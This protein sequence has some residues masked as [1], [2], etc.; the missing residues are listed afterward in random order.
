MKRVLGSGTGPSWDWSV[1]V[2]AL[3][4]LAAVAVCGSC[5]SANDPVAGWLVANIQQA[6]DTGPS[7][8]VYEG[9]GNFRVGSDAGAGLAVAFTLDSKGTGA[10]AGQTLVLYWPGHGRPG[11]GRYPLG[12]LSVQDGRLH[13]FTA[14]YQGYAA[15]QVRDF[16][17]FSGYVEFTASSEN[18]LVGTFQFTGGLYCVA[19][20][21]P[22]AENWCVLPTAVP[23]DSE[24]LDVSG[25]FVA[26]PAQG[27][28]FV[29][30][31]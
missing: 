1:S 7:G 23:P 31:T 21:Q 29:P 6:A 5:R 15:G 10:S 14:F 8:L 13:G 24:Q 27:G 4:L 30:G 19:S 17:A 3:G 18:L 12:P 2:M 22:S 28:A 16:T 11:P 25:S 9:T 26:G 20:E